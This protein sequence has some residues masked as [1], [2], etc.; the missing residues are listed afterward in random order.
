MHF[1]FI[2][3][4]FLF[5]QDLNLQTLMVQEDYYFSSWLQDHLQRLLL[6]CDL[7][8]LKFRRAFVHDRPKTLATAWILRA[9]LR[10]CSLRFVCVCVERDP[11]VLIFDIGHAPLLCLHDDVY[12]FHFQRLV[13]TSFSSS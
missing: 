8:S 6:S 9:A 10:H 12:T 4:F 13:S 2:C 3:P 1:V 11:Q 5:L 7:K